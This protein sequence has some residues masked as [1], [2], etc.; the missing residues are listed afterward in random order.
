MKR[1]TFKIFLILL[2]LCFLVP[3]QS[4]AFL[5]NWAIDFDGDGDLTTNTLNV[6]EQV[7]N[8]GTA[9]IDND[10]ESNS[11]NEWGTFWAPGADGAPNIPSGYELT[12]IFTASGSLDPATNTA[13]FASGALDIYVD[14]ALNYGSSTSMAD[15]IYYGA[16]DG[17]LIGGFDLTGGSGAI[18]PDNNA[19]NGIQTT[20]WE[21]NFLEEG[22]WFDENGN[23]LSFLDPFSFFTGIAT[24]NASWLNNFANAAARDEIYYEFAGNPEGLTNP[25]F[26][27]NNVEDGLW[28]SGNG[29]FRVNVI[30]EPAT[31]LLFGTGLLG[32]AGLGRRRFFKKS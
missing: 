21:S 17:T 22:Y 11:F 3:S 12:A 13:S 9:W 30:P 24:T 26:P 16:N 20:F 31:M 18:D 4:F 7:D 32:L 19:P 15:G 14:D 6:S 2:L 23:D 10:P 1:L 29:Q 5:T 25:A 28:F 27:P 8:A